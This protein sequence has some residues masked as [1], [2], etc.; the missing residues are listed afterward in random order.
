MSSSRRQ[1]LKGPVVGA[2][3]AAIAGRIAPALAADP[4]PGTPPAFGT[5]TGTG[6]A[7]TPATIA[8]AEKLMQVTFTTTERAQAAASWRVSMAPLYERRTG[9][10]KVA[11]EPTVAPAGLWNPA[12]PGV[13]IGPARNRFVRSKPSAARLPDKDD[14]IAFSP[15]HQL[16]RWIE[17]RQLTSERLT[18]IYLE[19]LERFQPKI[20]AVITLTR[21]LALSQAK[22]ADAEIAAGKSRGPLHGIPWGAKDLVDTAGIRTTY[23][24]EPFRNR[25]PTV[26]AATVAR[27]HQAGAVLVAKLSLGSLAL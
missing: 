4:P 1:F 9:P 25:V 15:V 5:G 27:L 6:P 7:I 22:Q 23:G 20:N 24:A 26:D 14:E 17:A 11:I 18:R 3:G 19:R 21:E 13:P 10:R 2:L 12:L 16:A 8:E